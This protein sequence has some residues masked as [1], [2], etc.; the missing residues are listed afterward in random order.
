MSKY[1]MEEFC[2]VVDHIKALQEYEDA[3]YSVQNEYVSRFDCLYH[4]PG[5]FPT[6]ES[7]LVD[8]LVKMFDDEDNWIPWWIYETDFG[9]DAP[10]VT[11]SDGIKYIIGTSEQLYYI[12]NGEWDKLES[13]TV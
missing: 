13:H 6:L 11:T 5:S 10:E 7:D 3:M 12:L 1:T 2:E 8:S 4:E 9:S